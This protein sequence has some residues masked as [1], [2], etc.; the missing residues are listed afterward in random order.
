METPVDVLDVWFSDSSRKRWFNSTPDFDAEILQRFER[1]ALELAKGPFPYLGWEDDANGT[2]AL[3]IA[4]DQFPRNMYRN[5]PKAFAWDNHALAAAERMVERGQDLDVE[6]SRRNFVYMPFMHSEDL[7]AQNRSVELSS[8]ELDDNGSTL[9]HAL[10]HRDVI[11]RFGRF[12]HRNDIL[13]RKSTA[14]ETKFLAD[15]GYNP[16]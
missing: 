4:L 16:S 8:T 5:K 7:A 14:E 12:P 1:T 11:K 6:I 2:L 3:I 10:A 13:G 15:G 9:R